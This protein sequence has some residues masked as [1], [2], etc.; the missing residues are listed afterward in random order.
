M[1]V[2]WVIRVMRTKGSRSTTTKLPVREAA[3][4]SAAGARREVPGEALASTAS[5]TSNVTQRPALLGAFRFGGGVLV[6]L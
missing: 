3:A 5:D 2:I 4:E 6:F 1:R